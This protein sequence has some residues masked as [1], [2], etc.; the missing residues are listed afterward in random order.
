M[1]ITRPDGTVIKGDGTFTLGSDLVFTGEDGTLYY[2]YILHGIPGSYTVD[3]FGADDVVLATTSFTDA[4]VGGSI[5]WEKRRQSDGDRV[6]GATFTVGGANGPFYCVGD[7]TNPV[8]IIDDGIRDSNDDAGEFL[9]NNVCPGTFTITE[10]IAP[11]GL[12]RDPD[13]TR[14]VTVTSGEPDQVI[15]TS[16][17]NFC[18]DPAPATDSDEEDFCNP[19][20]ANPRTIEWEKRRAS[21]S[22]LAGGAT[23]TVGGAPG[24][25]PYECSGDTT[26]PITVVDATSSGGL[27][28]DDTA[29]QLRLEDVCPGTYIITEVAA[30]SGLAIDGDPTREV[31]VTAGNDTIGTSTSGNGTADGCSTAAPHGNANA[32]TDSNETDFCNTAIT[33]RTLFWE[34]RRA[35]DGNRIGGAGS[36]LKFA[37]GGASG[38]F[39]CSGNPTNPVTIEDDEDGLDFDTTDG[40]IEMRNVCPGSYTITEVFTPSGLARDGD[41]TRLVNVTSAANDTIG[42]QGTNDG[43]STAAPHNSSATHSDSDETDF[44]NTAAAARSISWE[45]R[46]QDGG[47]LVGG[48][49]FTVG[50]S[51][52]TTSG[53]FACRGNLDNPLTVVD[54]GPFDSDSDD[55]QLRL[56][57]VC[58]GSYTI[59]ET[60][61]P[62]GFFLDP[63]ATRVVNVSTGD[64]SVSGSD[65][66]DPAPSTDTDE[67][68]F[69]NPQTVVGSIAWEK[70]S[71]TNG[72]LLGIATFTV[73]GASGPRS[74]LGDVT[75]P[76]A[77]ADNGANDFDS[78]AGQLLFENVCPGTYTV[79]ETVPP[80]TYS[81]DPDDTRSV[82]VG[83]TGTA[84]VIGTQG[85]PQEC[86]T[87]SPFGDP[88]PGTDSDEADFCNPLTPTNTAPNADDDAATVNED[89]GANTI[90]VLANDE[91]A[92]TGDTFAI[93]TT[94]DP[95]NGTVVITNSGADLTYAPDANYCNNPP[96]TS[97]DT[98][99]YTISD[100]EAIDTATVS[101]TVTCLN[102][103]PVCQAVSITVSEDGPEGTVAPNCNDVDD[104]TLTYSIVD[105]PTLGGASFSGG[106]LRFDPDGDFEGL[107]TGEQDTTNGDFTYKAYD[108]EDDSTAAG[109]GVTVNGANDAPV[110][111]DVSITTN[112]DTVGTVAPNCTDPDVETLSYSVVATPSLGDGTFSA[113]LLRFDPDG[114]FEGL[115]TGEQDT[116]NGDFTYRANDSTVDS[117]TAN[118]AVTVTGIND[119]PVLT[120]TPATYTGQYSD[121]I[122]T[123]SSA[124]GQQPI[125]LSATDV[126]DAGS[127]LDLSIRAQNC[128][129]AGDLP[130]DLALTDNGDGTGA[131]SGRFDVIPDIYIRCVRVTDGAAQDTET[132]TLDVKKE[133][134]SIVNIEPTSA[135]Y[136]NSGVA[137][138]ATFVEANDGF[139]STSLTT[140]NTSATAYAGTTVSFSLVGFASSSNS[141]SCSDGGGVDDGVGC[142]TGALNADAYEVTATIGGAWFTGGGIGTLAVID[143]ANGFA[144]G[145]GHFVWGDAPSPWQTPDPRVNFA[146]TGK[147]L[148]K[149]AQGGVLL[150]V[151]TADGSYVVKSN[152]FG[153]LTNGK[154]GSGPS[155]IWHTTMSGKATYGVPD[156][157]TI[158]NPYCGTGIRKCG[159]FQFLVYAEDRGEPGTLDRYRM[160]LIAPSGQV[161]FDMTLQQL[162]GGNVQ[163]PH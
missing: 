110:C 13:F 93:T 82:T 137:I 65:C 140:P 62:E 143:P 53:P 46:A 23:F 11:T 69:C 157:P 88:V 139:P 67:S 96:G 100:G 120:L 34:K 1:R 36:G 112:E 47:G 19:A 147:Q 84:E 146:F 15:G 115:D 134:A 59:T 33:A 29:G 83:P 76:I 150:V 89:S 116:T 49:T 66:P 101:V 35:S 5:G 16:S 154:T 128:T 52:A 95:A 28:T 121:P 10:T 27:D 123:N 125:G 48:A 138:T 57:N 86:A 102:D 74:C 135:V 105:N 132:L 160:K 133:D 155:T 141:G 50:G 20:L 73:G 144:T 7:T 161:V 108:G 39:A 117:N 3:A 63:D 64:D 77:V 18:P 54:D 58:S 21:S 145:G 131:I 78:D 42:S 151:H 4:I 90:N 71:H 153:G 124:A 91:D 127:E 26:N 38:P 87:S 40:E 126:D 149:G 159:N 85:S 80:S 2:E 70:R 129:D 31:N 75:N 114:D 61:A 119:A 152:S 142:T 106:L 163:V 107:D 113:G 158:T 92:D 104:A 79:T 8:E 94:S 156:V 22:A 44:C 68:D 97:P 111:E 118:V 14:I 72:A 103:A 45:K 81:V 9:L 37:V 17:A 32:H 51:G 6:E 122:D 56:S 162:A 98:F 30:P 25:G 43:C 12:V 136:P 109:V 130:N 41:P 148:K 60:I 24:A 55:G 99:T